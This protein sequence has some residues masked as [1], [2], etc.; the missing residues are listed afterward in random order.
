MPVA[1]AVREV[2]VGITGTGAD[3]FPP[4]WLRVSEKYGEL[5]LAVEFV[6]V[7]LAKQYTRSSKLPSA[8]PAAE[9]GR[10]LT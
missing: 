1:L 10:L 8:R 2:V 4:D 5:A 6:I 3:Q 9:S 7:A